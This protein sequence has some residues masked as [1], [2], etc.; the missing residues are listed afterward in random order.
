MIKYLSSSIGKKQL[1]ALSGFALVLFLLVHLLGNFAIFIG[2]EALNEYSKKLHSLGPL[3][4]VARLGLI[5]VFFLHFGL[6]G[7]LVYENLKARGGS[8]SKP[9][10]KK[11]RSLFT[12]TM[13]VSG[14]IVFLYIGFHLYDY[15]FTPHSEA[16]STV[17]GEFLGLYG[18][19]YNSFLNPLRSLFYIFTMFA[20]GFHLIHGVQSVI[21]TFGFNHQTY[22]PIIKKSS[23]VVA[24]II[25]VGFS[26]IPVFVMLHNHFGWSIKG[27]S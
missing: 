21:Q 17:R 7:L 13:R 18:H 20:I 24:M 12:K 23:W 16:I 14:V 27:V 11:T 10:H 9:L 6:V 5:G 22:T 25:S 26:S 2:P 8:Y 3:L 15:T 4:W 19:V 1:V